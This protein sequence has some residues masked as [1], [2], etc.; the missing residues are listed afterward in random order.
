MYAKVKELP[1]TLQRAL[2]SV[3]YSKPDIEVKTAESYSLNPNT[4][5]SGNRGYACAVNL[6]TGDYRSVNGAWGGS[7]PFENTIDRDDNR[8]AMLP[9]MAI[10][11]GESGGRGHFADITV[12]PNTLA[13]L[14][15]APSVELTDNQKIVLMCMK[16]LKSFARKDEARRVGVNESEYQLALSQLAQMK[17]IKVAVN[18]ASQIT[19]E[20]KNALA[21]VKMPEK[22]RF[23]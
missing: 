19:T 2:N 22:A 20:G 1:S 13:A 12:A 5:F 6:D 23:L 10:I 9:N 11:K 15:P 17:L 4:A 14:L 7:N 21:G 16:R 18:G 8:H 3:G